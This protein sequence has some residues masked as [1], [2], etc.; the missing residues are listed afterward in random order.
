[1][2]E[3]MDTWF[4]TV[5]NFSEPGVYCIGGTALL[6]LWGQLRSLDDRYITI[7]SGNHIQQSTIHPVRDLPPHIGVRLWVAPLDPNLVYKV[8]IPAGVGSPPMHAKRST[9]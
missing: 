7:E 4:P 8:T 6:E 1:M 2:V 3:D 9:W 5:S